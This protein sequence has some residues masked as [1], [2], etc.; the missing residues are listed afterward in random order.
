MIMFQVP[1]KVSFNLQVE[2][3]T[4]FLYGTP[5]KFW[6]KCTVAEIGHV[7][8]PKNGSFFEIPNFRQKFFFWKFLYGTPQKLWPK[9][10]VGEI[11][12]GSKNGRSKCGP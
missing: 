1:Q 10:P 2:I 8:G 6:P 4:N 11:G 12:H 7:T 3:M 9:W 5:Q